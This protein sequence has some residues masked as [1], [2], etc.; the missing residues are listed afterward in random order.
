MSYNS[1]NIWIIHR[2]PSCG[3]S[4]NTPSKKDNIFWLE[5]QSM[6]RKLHNNFNCVLFLFR[7][8]ATLQIIDS[9]L[10]YKNANMKTIKSTYS[11]A[12][13]PWM[14]PS[15]DRIA[16]IN[17]SGHNSNFIKASVSF[18]T[19]YQYSSVSICGRVI[20]SIDKHSFYFVII[21]RAQF[22]T[23]PVILFDQ[24]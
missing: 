1:F 23:D 3:I 2:R 8:R 10:F 4:S 16:S 14:I 15:Q 19:N 17:R 18:R 13:K 5:F 11:T 6:D 20:S 7:I 12:A 21:A 22:I 24:F 9:I